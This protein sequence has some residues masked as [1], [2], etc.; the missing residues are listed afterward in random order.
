MPGSV[1]SISRPLAQWRCLQCR[2]KPR[3]F[4]AALTL[5]DYAMPLDRLILS[6]KR[7][8]RP[9]LAKAV[10]EA[11]ASTQ[12]AHIPTPRWPDLVMPVPLHRHRLRMRGF[13]QSALLAGVLARR[14]QLPLDLSSLI[15]SRDTPSQQALPLRERHH[16]MRHAFCCTR[17]LSNRRIAL[18]D[19]VMT[20]A[21][22]LHWA[23]HA[24][25]QAG[26]AS[27]IVLT[28]ARTP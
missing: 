14:W 18:V 16:N 4:D 5:A 24:L 9:H 21:A 7:G 12:L 17:P 2:Q 6:A 20:S 26:A 22:T 19:D 27:V 11:L 1:A 3:A 15:R 10:G 23:S 13:N 25:R 8:R 28:V